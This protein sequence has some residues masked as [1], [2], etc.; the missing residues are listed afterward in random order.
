[1]S[2]PVCVLHSIPAIPGRRPLYVCFVCAHHVSQRK[3]NYS[4]LVAVAAVALYPRLSP[5]GTPKHK[6]AGSRVTHR[7]LFAAT[8]LRWACARDI[9]YA[10]V[11]ASFSSRKL[12]AR[13]P[14]G[15]R[16]WR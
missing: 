9:F 5:P 8:L 13:E 6:L 15:R 3:A 4:H 7:P 16:A 11:R 1:M 10:R 2:S 14:F 12:R